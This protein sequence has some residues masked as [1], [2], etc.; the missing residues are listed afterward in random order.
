MDRRFDYGGACFCGAG[1]YYG[2]GGM[3]IKI[4]RLVVGG[5]VIMVVVMGRGVI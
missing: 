2:G 5:W 4:D 3:V 1:G